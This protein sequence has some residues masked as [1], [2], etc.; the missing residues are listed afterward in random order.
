M[1]D[2][3]RPASCYTAREV[4]EMRAGAA[5]GYEGPE[6]RLGGHSPAD[7]EKILDV[8]KRF[9]DGTS[10]MQRIELSIVDLKA[11]HSRFEDKLDENTAKTDAT[12]ASTE[13]ILDIVLLGKSFF[14]LAEIFGKV[15][16]WGAGIATAVIGLWLTFKYG[17]PSP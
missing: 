1:V 2:Q 15:I 14:R 11:A 6:R 4:A 16:K 7:C 10:R 13:E 8:E 17:K 12:A 3:Y 5:R 9:S